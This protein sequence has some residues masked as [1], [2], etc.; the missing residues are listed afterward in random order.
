MK[1]VKEDMPASGRRKPMWQKY[2]NDIKAFADGDAETVRIELDEEEKKLSIAAVLRR[3]KLAIENVCPGKVGV[4]IR[5]GVL[6]LS[7]VDE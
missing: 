4:F 7:K 6:Y 1:L 2:A 5:K 3:V